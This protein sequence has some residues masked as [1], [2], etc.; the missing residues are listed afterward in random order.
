MKESKLIIWLFMHEYLNIDCL[1]HIRVLIEKFT[2]QCQNL[3]KDN[4]SMRQE[5]DRLRLLEHLL[6][7]SF[8]IEKFHKKEGWYNQ[9][10]EKKHPEKNVF[11]ETA[12]NL[13]KTLELRGKK[14]LKEDFE[15]EMKKD[16]GEFENLE[17]SHEDISE[18]YEK[19]RDGL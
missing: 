15:N 1:R 6:T 14:F 7:F 3:Y 8:L 4:H 11:E 9:W 12:T 17:I 19:I 5:I 18:Y 16:Y 13:V 2:N 10:E